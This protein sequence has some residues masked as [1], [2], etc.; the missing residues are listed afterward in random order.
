LKKQ[1]EEARKL[2]ER[3]QKAVEREAKVKAAAK[4]KA[5]KT[6]ATAEEKARKATVA[7]EEKAQKTALAA[8]KR[9]EKGKQR[10]E[11]IA[12]RNMNTRQTHH[13]EQ[14]TEDNIPVGP[15]PNTELGLTRGCAEAGMGIGVNDP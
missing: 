9:A 14:E 8:E 10:M 7:A 1:E 2:A 3:L 13:L 15:L 4:E 12:Q 5:Q 11:H 6:A